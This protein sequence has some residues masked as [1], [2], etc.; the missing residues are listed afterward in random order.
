V[1]RK[2]YTQAIGRSGAD[3]PVVLTASAMFLQVPLEHFLDNGRAA[4]VEAA[5]AERTAPGNGLAVN[6]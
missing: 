3:G 2:V 6:P 1:G 4:D 5:V